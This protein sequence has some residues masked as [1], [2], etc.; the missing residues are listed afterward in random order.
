[1]KKEDVMLLKLVSGEQIICTVISAGQSY[2][3]IKDPFLTI[4]KMIADGQISIEI[5]PWA[6]GVEQGKEITINSDTVVFDVNPSDKLAEL[7][8]EKVEPSLIKV[9]P[10][11]SMG[12]VSNLNLLKG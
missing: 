5:A 7:Y 6:V 4:P 1:M 3:K 12:N 10:K 11:P 2:I 8:I 9:P